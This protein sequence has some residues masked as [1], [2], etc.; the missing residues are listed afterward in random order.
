MARH[1]LERTIR[2][3]IL[4]VVDDAESSDVAIRV[5]LRLGELFS[6]R[7]LLVST[8]DGEA[9]D[10]RDGN[11]AAGPW[12]MDAQRLL[13]WAHA[14]L[15]GTRVEHRVAIGS[16]VDVVSE[17]AAEEMAELIVVG[18][19]GGVRRGTLRSWLA[20]ELAIMAPCPVVV[21]PPEPA[22]AAGSD[23]EPVAPPAAVAHRVG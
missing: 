6:A 4:C 23:P 8:P 22:V 2:G 13:D 10:L 18:A 21:V 17:I 14:D 7:V 11:D 20:R 19:D 16:P 3:T 15:A 9:E 1:D 12:R 5:A